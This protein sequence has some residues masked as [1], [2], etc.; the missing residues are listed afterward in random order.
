[1]GKLLGFLEYDREE[2]TKRSVETRIRDFREF[3]SWLSSEQLHRQA[4]RCMDCG[5]PHC[6]MF[7]CPTQNRIP[8]WNDLVYR[9]HYRRALEVLHATNNF[10]E[11]T[12]RVCPAPCEAACT[13]AINR[14]AVAIRQI[15]LTLAELGWQEEWIRPEPAPFRTGR[16]VA[17]I[18]SGPAGLAAAQQLA[19]R[20]H[21][22]VVFERQPRPGGILRYGIPDFKLEKWVI[23]R[24]LGQLIEE[25]VKFETEVDVGVDVSIR[26]LR[27]TFD[28]IVLTIGAGKP[29]DLQVP[30]R[31][32]RGV[33]FA[34]E[35]LT[36]QNRVLAGETIPAA[37]RISAKGKRVVVV[38]GGDTGSDCVGTARRQGASSITQ[39][40]ILPRP[41]LERPPDN[42]WPTWPRVLRNSSS[43]EE[44]CDRLW[45]VTTKEFVGSGGHVTA[46]RIAEV[47]WFVG[48][49]NGRWEFR[50][51]PGSE[52]LLPADLVLLAMG[53]EGPEHGPLIRGLGV[54][55]D[56]RGTIQADDQQRTSVPGV[57]V[58]GDAA[59]GA[60][61]V[62]KAIRHGRKVAES[63]DR[64]LA[65]L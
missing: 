22:V 1:M 17:V 57:F 7:G 47:E 15:E 65:S 2:A 45:S 63:V 53:F 11:I 39:L 13:L 44:G 55:L 21:E 18:G 50:E 23:D 46:L 12:G 60:S 59:M 16:R 14:K 40:E 6:H 41:P 32:L 27:R 4:A 56:G 20:G 28:A 37:Q 64:F 52:R 61:L 26:Y 25:G 30:G 38:G 10:P 9:R 29:R 49:G 31:N 48:E 43:H 8:D 62:V 42:P 35:F 5:V 58:A 54:A 36:Q 24:R 34:M 33:H 3:E 19:R 51:V